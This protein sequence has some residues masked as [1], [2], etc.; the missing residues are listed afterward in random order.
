V[1]VKL[2]ARR[3]VA[4]VEAAPTAEEEAAAGEEATEEG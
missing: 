3:V 1:I 4:E 2:A